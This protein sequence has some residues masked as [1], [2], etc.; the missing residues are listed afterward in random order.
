MRKENWPVFIVLT[1]HF[2]VELPGIEPSP[3]IS[4]TCGNIEFCD[5]K[6]RESTLNDLR[7]RDGC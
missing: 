5:A 3:K 4:L 7:R 2:S 1:S 6:R